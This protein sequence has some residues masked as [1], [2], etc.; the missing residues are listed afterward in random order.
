[1]IYVI[2][3]KFTKYAYIISILK[4]QDALIIAQVFL[5]TIFANYGILN[6]VILNKD[7]LFTSKFWK[8]LIAFLKMKQKMSTAFYLQINI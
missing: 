3:N 6:E 2:T 1:L 7:K 8:T 4:T 5:Q